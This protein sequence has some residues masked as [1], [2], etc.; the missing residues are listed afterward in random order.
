MC[1]RMNDMWR[2]ISER[3]KLSEIQILKREREWEDKRDK[4]AAVSFIKRENLWI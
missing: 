2:R 1:E 3:N 4:D